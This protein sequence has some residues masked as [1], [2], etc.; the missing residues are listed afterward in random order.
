LSAGT[1]IKGFHCR[2]AIVQIVR[3]GL[4]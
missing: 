1:E 3:F 2:V 4:P